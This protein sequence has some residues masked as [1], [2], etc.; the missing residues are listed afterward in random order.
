[1][2]TPIANPLHDPTKLDEAPR[3]E[4]R[5]TT[6]STLED[7]EL[8]TWEVASDPTRPVGEARTDLKEEPRPDPNGRPDPIRMGDHDPIQMGDHELMA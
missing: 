8:T 1:M 3:S 4:G 5:S 7:H 2:A 6:R